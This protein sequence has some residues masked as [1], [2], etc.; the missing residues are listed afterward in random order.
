MIHLNPIYAFLFGV[1]WGF[2]VALITGMFLGAKKA[3]RLPGGSIGCCLILWPLWAS[4][5]GGI[6]GFIIFAALA[7][8]KY[9]R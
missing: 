4:I 8:D 5:P 7:R 6:V 1:L 3:R 2:L 9:E